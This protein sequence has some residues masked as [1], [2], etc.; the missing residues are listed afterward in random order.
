MVLGQP[1]R[2]RRHALAEVRAR[3]TRDHVV[4]RLLRGAHAEEG[5]GGDHEGAE[6]QAAFRRR[7]HPFVVDRDQLAQRL[8]ELGHRQLRQGQARGGTL[9]AR[10]VGVGAEGPDRAVG[11]PVGL[12]A[13]EDFL[14]VMQH[15][16][17]RIQRQRAVGAHLRV[18]PA[19]RLVPL[20]GDHVVGE[21]LA[22]A[23]LAGQD[24][25]ALRVAAGVVG[26]GDLVGQRCGGIHAQILRK[27]CPC[28]MPPKPLA[29]DCGYQPKV[30]V[31]TTP[32]VSPGRTCTFQ[33]YSAHNRRTI[34]R[35]M[36]P[37]CECPAWVPR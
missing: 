37:P 28:I 22:E 13:F 26:T 5:L 32:R 18:V 4:R 34:D 24:R 8:G 15:R 33:P 12:D 36:P 2:D 35:P 17:G 3:R 1:D 20:D 11:M 23:D 14:A 10:A 30:S 6:I 16:R 27:R 21:M 9:Q 19:I 31:A 7:R 29:L 25:R